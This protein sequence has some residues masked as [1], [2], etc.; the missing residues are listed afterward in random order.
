MSR[1]KLCIAALLSLT[2]A[3]VLGDVDCPNIDVSVMGDPDAT[4]RLCEL[5]SR[6]IDELGACSLP[7]G[8]TVQ[9]DLVDAL[10]QGCVGQY[11]CGEGRIELLERD[12]L[13]RSLDPNGPFSAIDPEEYFYSIL[14]H[15]LAHAALETMDCP[16]ESCLATQEYVAFAMQ[17]QSYSPQARATVLTR[18]DFDRPITTDEINPFILLMAPDVFIQKVWRHF[19]QQ[20]DPCDF[21]GEIMSGDF[22]FDHALQ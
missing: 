17:M 11:H 20:E 14:V 1:L 21:I 6:A 4:P 2:A 12:T 3:P 15:E 9:I 5:T 8:G 18:P 22:L 16:F 7:I 13:Q 10:P 19:S